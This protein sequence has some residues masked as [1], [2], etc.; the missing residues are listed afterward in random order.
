MSGGRVGR[1]GGGGG[2]L[3]GCVF[4]LAVTRRWSLVDFYY[5]QR[6]KTERLC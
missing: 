6:K 5:Y 4:G 1:E 3:L 2:C